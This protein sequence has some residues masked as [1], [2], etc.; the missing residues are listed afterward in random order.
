MTRRHAKLAPAATPVVT[1][2]RVRAPGR[3][4][5]REIAGGRSAVLLLGQLDIRV[6]EALEV[7]RIAPWG[8]PILVESNGSVV[9]VGRGLARKVWV[10]VLGCE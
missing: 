6:G 9:A 7:Q 8:G 5:V 3:V 1:L 2:D 4:Q 10:E